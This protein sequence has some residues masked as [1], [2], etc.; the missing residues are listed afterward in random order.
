MDFQ[1]RLFLGMIKEIPGDKARDVLNAY[2]ILEEFLQDEYMAGNKLTIADLSLVASISS[3][4]PIIPVD[5]KKCP[6]LRKWF[7]RMQAL[8]YYNEANQ[9]PLNKYIEVIK[10]NLQ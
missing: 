9:I 8:P 7:S 3:L 5:S 1:R 4:D 2:D 10:R 6:K